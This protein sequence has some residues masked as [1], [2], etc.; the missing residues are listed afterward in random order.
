MSIKENENFSRIAKLSEGFSKLSWQERE[1]RLIEMDILTSDEI[2][3]LH[4]ETALSGH[5]ADHFVENTVG[6]FPLPLG[7]ALNFRIDGDDY[8]IP[9][10]IEETS[11]I[12]GASKTAKFIRDNGEITTKNLSELGIGQ[13]HIPRVK[14]FNELQKIIQ[15]NK[16]SFIEM[17]NENVMKDIVTRGGGVKE[18]T[19]RCLPRGD[20]HDMAVI[21]VMIDTRDAMGANTI[22]QVCEYL[23]PKIEE[24][25][26]EELGMCIL[27]NLTDTR[28]TQ[29]KAVIYNIDPE[30]GE[31]IAEGSL[32]AQVDPYRATTNNKGVMNGI[33]GVL[34][35]TG[36]DW[37]AV[38]AGV[39]AYAA[40]SGKYTSITRWTM[41]GKDLHG[42][43]EAPILVG[44]VGGVTRLHPI[45]QICLK[46]LG[47]KSA[48]Q[49][50][51]IIAAVGL[52]QNLA[53]IRALVTEGITQGH[54]KL[55]IANI[56]MALGASDDELP[57]L[58]QRLA[59]RLQKNRRITEA[60]AREIINELRKH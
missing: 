41:E 10:A 35:A 26:G 4:K 1:K 37:R 44:I 3:I 60:D 11:V 40:R 36:N 2:Q 5:L 18:I 8:V 23:K 32:F 49:L 15:E 30:L 58:K 20:G 54:M 45:A 9:M 42:V 55:H 51:R 34:I 17:A 46:I 6:F 38:E 14:K 7:V 56:V 31:A 57:I 12:A 53:A 50:S 16:K 48:S 24:L 39:H 33:D 25:S 47:I 59:E 22:N 21:H 27:S 52:V 28:I 13:I 19:L 29:A 43:I